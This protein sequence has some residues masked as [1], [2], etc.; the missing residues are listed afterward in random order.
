MYS[1]ENIRKQI[2]L[3]AD[4]IP[5]K[6]PNITIQTNDTGK[7]LITGWTRTIYF[8]N[9]SKENILNELD[10][11]KTSFASLS[12]SFPEINDVIRGNNFK[13]EFHMAYDDYGKGGIALCSEID[14]ILK[15]YIS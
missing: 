1:E 7:L 3:L 15:W 4:R 5:L 12:E 14:G 11:L 13:V 6:L 9:I 2:W 10:D 8:H